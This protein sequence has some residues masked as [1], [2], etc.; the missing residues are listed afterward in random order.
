MS[1][2]FSLTFSQNG[3]TISFRDAVSE[4]ISD[5]K[6]LSGIKNK[7]TAKKEIKGVWTAWL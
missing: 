1:A 5:K 7:K 2:N 4:K 3:I 6:K